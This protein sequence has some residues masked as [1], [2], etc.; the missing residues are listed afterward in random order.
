M[1]NYSDNSRSTG[2]TPDLFDIRLHRQIDEPVF[3]NHAVARCVEAYERV[4]REWMDRYT[5]AD[6]N[7]EDMEESDTAGK[8]EEGEE[9][10]QAELEGAARASSTALKAAGEA[11]RVALPPLTGEAN[12]GDFVACVA[13]GM[14]LGVFTANEGSK[15][16]YAAQVASFAESRR[17]RSRMVV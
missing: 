15:L 16:L 7:G 2:T 10:F 17:A 4:F 13:H 5:G 8:F 12:I 9:D 3:A 1:H 11:F 14:V 6:E